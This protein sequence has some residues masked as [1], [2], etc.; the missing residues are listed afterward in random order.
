MLNP[1]PLSP[2]SRMTSSTSADH[3]GTFPVVAEDR[4]SSERDRRFDAVSAA[5]TAAA[6]SNTEGGCW[7]EMEE[8]SALSDIATS[9]YKQKNINSVSMI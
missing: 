2:F 7:E 1:S 6:G 8:A 3:M 9:W 5:A 4:L